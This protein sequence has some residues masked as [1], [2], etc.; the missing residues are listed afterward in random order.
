MITQQKTVLVTGGAGHVGSHLIEVLLENPRSRVIA[1]DSDFNGR[2]SNHIV[3]AEYREG[4]TKG[5]ATLVPERLD[6]V[7]RLGEYARISTSI[8]DIVQV[9]IANAVGTFAVAEYCRAQAV[10]KLV[11]AGSSTK[12][13]TE[14]DG[15]QTVCVCEGNEC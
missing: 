15:R 1:L 12:V 8:E 9:F 10:D 4:H 3:G 6:I 2:K 5:N 11:H 7:F 14:G 13:A